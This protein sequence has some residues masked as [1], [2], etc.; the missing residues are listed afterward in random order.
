MEG[1]FWDKLGLLLIITGLII[2]GIGA[3]ASFA[4]GAGLAAFFYL[5]FIMALAGFAIAVL[6]RFGN[7]KPAG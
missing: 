3:A 6:A 1:S 4:W 2:A 7:K 5:G